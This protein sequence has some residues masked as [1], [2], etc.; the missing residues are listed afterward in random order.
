MG[1]IFLS[2]KSRRYIHVV[3]IIMSLSGQNY[4]VAIKTSSGSSTGKPAIPTPSKKPTVA[5]KSTG[6]TVATP[7]TPSTTTGQSAMEAKVS[8]TIT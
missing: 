1:I 3:L 4:L 8:K 5:G 7:T 2:V 6:P